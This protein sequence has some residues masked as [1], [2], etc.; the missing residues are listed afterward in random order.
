MG[1]SIDLSS[2]NN[3]LTLL[4]NL[5]ATGTLGAITNI[6]GNI[7]LLNYAN[8]AFSGTLQNVAGIWELGLNSTA[9]STVSFTL[10]VYY[11]PSNSTLSG[12]ATLGTL[13][14]FQNQI[15]LSGVCA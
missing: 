1:A 6:T 9:T 13:S 5:N 3:D 4:G 14:L 2:G 12:S 8:L 11:S 15:T 7:D 10:N